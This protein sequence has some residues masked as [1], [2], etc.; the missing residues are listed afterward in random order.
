MG[1]M[2]K[3]MAIPGQMS[4]FDLFT[5]ETGQ[6][7]GTEGITDI[8]AEGAEA[9]QEPPAF[10]IPDEEIDRIL[11]DGGLYNGTKFRIMVLY[12][13]E[14][15]PKKRIQYLKQEYG[16]RERS[17]QFMDDSRGYVDYSPK[18]I[19]IRSYERDGELLQG[20]G[21]VEKRIGELIWYGRYLTE[22]QMERYAQMEES[23]R[24]AGGIPLPPAAPAFPPVP[25]KTDAG[26]SPEEPDNMGQGQEE[27]QATDPQ[28][29]EPQ[30]AEAQETETQEAE[31][32][33]IPARNF[34]ITDDHIGEGGPKQKFR[35]NM[36]AIRTLQKIEAGD[37]NAT[38]E[39]Q[40]VLSGYVG[41][42]GL[43]DAFD[44]KKDAWAAEYAE[45]KAA[46]TQEEY[47]AARASTLNAYYTPPVVIKAVYEAVGKMGFAC[48]NI[49]EPSMGTGNFFGLLPE[50]MQDSR[51]YGVEL[52]SITGRIAQKLY[53]NADI[54][55]A[56][57]EDTDRRGFYDLCVG[58]IP[59]GDYR[60][61]D[62]AYNRLG[63]AVHNYFLAKATGQV[64]PGGILALLTSRYT[65]DAKSPDARE[66]IAQRAE[67]LGAIRLPNNAFKANA[68]TEAVA[69]IL[70]LQ[71]REHPTDTMPDWVRI[72]LTE[73]GLAVNSYFIAHPEMVL[74]E[75]TATSTM[76][77]REG[78]TVR[79]VPGA[80][81]GEQLKAAIA[82]IHGQYRAV[83]AG[84]GG[85]G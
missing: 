9:V 56:G 34:R 54:T 6:A 84:N 76:Y 65:M 81:L 73:H 45:L 22:A 40:E 72:G 35:A 1:R 5:M 19:R 43:A 20:W 12:R 17:W 42:G 28:I 64:R 82:N 85:A 83:A 49:L 11:Q 74:G 30:E 62:K 14:S 57:F 27:P 47:A 55:V 52:D 29:T 4:L 46:L 71:K 60:V 51:L 61:N 78:V 13:R 15:D 10:V 25:E 37:R 58:N 23:Y 38:P 59:Y 8:K 21:R 41:W 53:P 32:Q 36:D 31:P 24:P 44:G 26:I 16:T 50:G 63:F 67:L 48:G 77:G 69:D 7:G 18:G 33:Q 66:Y 3:T 75:L 39:E 70:F 68:G 80:D 79:P 2:K